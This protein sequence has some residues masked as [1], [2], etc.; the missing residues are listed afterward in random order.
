MKKVLLLLLSTFASTYLTA[1]DF[2]LEG[3]IR[4]DW[5]SD[6]G[7]YGKILSLQGKGSINDTFSYRFRHRFNKPIGNYYAFDAT[8]LAYIGI[9]ASDKLN[10]L[11]GK[12]TFLQ[13]GWEYNIAP[14]DSYVPSILCADLPCYQFALTSKYAFNEGK[15]E[16]SFQVSN[17]PY[18]EL[19]SNK[20]ALSLAW[21]GHHGFFHSKYSINWFDAFNDNKA[22]M[23][24][25]GNKFVFNKFS[26]YLDFI[27]IGAL[28]D[29][30][31]FMNSNTVLQM[32][33]KFNDKFNI[34][35]KYSYDHN[36]GNDYPLA[37]SGTAFQRIAGGL[38]YF[39]IGDAI[40]L[41]ALLI[42]NTGTW[43]L[44]TETTHFSG[45]VFNVG[46]TCKLK[47]VDKT[48]NN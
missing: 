1:Q 45:V 15:D 4:F 47:L 46:I 37:S 20:Y 35:A 18:S 38:E 25:F 14:V 23:F 16:L 42:Y 19:G 10:F 17:N 36:S 24:A 12:Q 21:D 26:T 9:K 48:K 44:G 29:G 5:A 31:P 3:D 13:G 7:F 41:H 28:Y 40:R 27:S 30:D 43:V 8:D 33:Y 6:S 34:F 39:P 32:D 2:H 22:F 11:L